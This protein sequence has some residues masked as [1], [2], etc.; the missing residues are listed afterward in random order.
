MACRQFQACVERV[1][2]LGNWTRAELYAHDI[3]EVSYFFLVF[4]KELT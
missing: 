1:P 2:Q 4:W 3:I